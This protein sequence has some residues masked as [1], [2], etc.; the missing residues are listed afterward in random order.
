MTQQV[1]ID[2]DAQIDGPE[3][4]GIHDLTPTLGYQRVAIVN[5]MYYGLPGAPDGQWVLIDCGV[6]G[7]TGLITK[8]IE[9][10]FGKSR[11]AAII[12]TH[13]HFDHIGA[14][15][16]LAE[17]WNVPIYAHP[18]EH[19]Y[20]D[21]RSSYPPPDPSVGGGLMAAMSGLYPSG[22]IDVSQ[23]LQP[24]PADGTVPGMPDWKWIHTPGHAPGHVSLWCESD[25]TLI[26]GDAFITTSQESAYAV[27]TQAPEIHGPPKYFTPDWENAR[28]SVQK[29][30]ALEPELVITG[31]GR[32]MHGA[33]MRAA[34]QTL[35]ANFDTIA[36]PDHGRYVHE[37]ARADETGVT[38]VPPK[39]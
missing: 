2:P 27:A 5:L 18:L 36:V 23:W 28:A 16:H 39:S 32:P 19:P 13:G 10:R 4:D 30:A 7:T 20:L 12:M 37:P 11:P 14:L 25:R 9:S 17:L 8:A 22:P 33:A 31:H 34:L 38:Y 24:L 3:H 15:K 6:M 1:P 35:A 26:V 29:L 21:G